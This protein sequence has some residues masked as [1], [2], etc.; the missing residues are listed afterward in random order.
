M[1]IGGTQRLII[2]DWRESDRTLFHE[3]NADPAVM[4]F[5]AMRRDRQE[6]DAMMDR[7]NDM[8]HSTGFGF[9]ALENRDT[10]EPIGFCGISPVT[11]DGIFAPGT[12]E[13]GWRLTTR[14]WGKGYITE[15]AKSLLTMA[16]DDRQ[17]AE[18]VSFAVHDNHRSTAVMKRI[19]LI[20]DPSRDFSHPRVPDTLAHLQPHVTYALS[21]AQWKEMHRHP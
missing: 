19:G 20:R 13:I 14:H 7:I 8:I 15:A 2:R 10:C 4:A 11:V 21:L 17:L 18:I 1:I 6:A 12:M 5:F 16:F 3:L 9:Y